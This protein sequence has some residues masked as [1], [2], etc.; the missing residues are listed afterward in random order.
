MTTCGRW[1][2]SLLLVAVLAPSVSAAEVPQEKRRIAPANGPI[3]IDGNLD[4]AGWQGALRYDTWFETRPGDNAEPKVKTVGYIAYDAQF[5]YAAFDMTDPNPGK[6]RGPF[7]DHDAINGNADDFAGVILD[8]RNDGKTGYEFFANA[9]GTQFDAV[10]DDS[11]GNEDAS[12]DFFW[13]VATRKN[14][15]GWTLEMRIPF[16]SLRYERNVTEWGVMLYRNY[17]RE[18]RYQIFTSRLPRGSNCFVCHFGKV[19][20]LENLPHG[21]HLVAAPYLAARQ[22]GETRDGLGSSLVNKPISAD[23]GADVKWTP[24]ADSAVD[25][26]INPD[27]S[28]VEADAAV[29]STNE[30]FAI[31]FPEK[32]PFFL[33][34]VE[35][36]SSPLQA[37]Y[38]RTITSPRWGMRATGKLGSNAY[39]LLVAD[40]RGG[41]SV[42]IPATFGSAFADQNLS[43]IAAVTRLRHDFGTAGSFVS[44]LGTLREVSGGAHNRVFGPDFQWKNEKNTITGQL[45]LSDTQT[46][47]RPDLGGDE[48]TGKKLRGYAGDLWYQYS[49]RANDLYVEYRDIDNEFR[50]DNGFIP[51]VGYRSSYVEGGH[52]WYPKD[53][54]VTRVRTF[55]I[56]GYDSTEEGALLYR[57]TSAGFGADGKYRSF[58]RLRFANE[59]VRDGESVYDRDVLYY[60]L[61]FTPPGIVSNVSI[62][63]RVGQD[64]DFSNGRGARGSNV[65]VSCNVRPSDH[66]VIGLSASNRWL[67]VAPDGSTSDRLFTSQVER[68]RAT[69]TFNNRTFARVI[70]QNSRTNRDEALYVNGARQHSGGFATQLLWA[71]KL[72]WQTLVYA[73]M[74]DLR[75]VGLD[76]ELEPSS[77]Q[78]FMKVSYAFQR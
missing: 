45:L 23:V 29:I 36:F 77:R 28:Q 68:I 49:T 70:L 59:T 25:A 62:D 9:S 58:L 30:R 53:R 48:W 13:D 57:R 55:A 7:G 72:N 6:I 38:T 78:F 74:G 60:T 75:E 14:D 63:G 41:G 15:H 31:F 17:P 37:V 43:S 32:R 21:G 65:S 52:T 10:Q 24:T 19:E 69:Y 20:G 27:F 1:L 46:P 2:C 35:L 50:A 40:D 39:T 71:Y 22:I 16:S 5:F 11:S 66:L 64:V 3:T 42:I 33:E 56:G 61:Q 47:D 26:T 67:T 51:Q 18:H 54:F 12:P 4:D 73:G 76:G 44:F 8:T 34:G